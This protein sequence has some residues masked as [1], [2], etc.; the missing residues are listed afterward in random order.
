[1]PAPIQYPKV[2]ISDI[3]EETPDTKTFVLKP[4]DNQDLPY[5]AGQFIT[6]V[7]PE[8][9]QDERRSY[10]FSSS[11][12]ADKQV[13]IT[14][15]RIQNGAF[16]RK[17][18]DHTKIGDELAYSGISGFFKLPEP[19]EA[20]RQL[21]FF[22]AGSGIGPN[23]SLIKTVLS[24]YPSIQVILIYSNRNPENTI[25]F[26]ELI[27]LQKKHRD[28]FSI[29]FLMSN[30]KDILFSRLNNFLLISLLQKYKKGDWEDCYFFICG[31][32]DY[33]DTVSIT[34]L[35]EGVS[36]ATIRKEN[37]KSYIPEIKNIPTDKSKRKVTLHFQNNEYEFDVQYPQTI[38]KA[39]LENDIPLP[40]SCESGQCGTC[41]AICTKGKVWMSYNEVLMPRELRQ[42]IILTCTGY[43]I[44]GDIEIK[45]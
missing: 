42:N 22:A 30:N 14:V 16:S 17:L 41:S 19:I 33:M 8:E 4:K 27:E 18:I 9:G 45:I 36:P 3:I 26:K 43:P 34:L 38:L 32:V 2:I 6:L 20:Y 25:F 23:F 31:P 35:T 5:A 24:L 39:A 40:F 29:E 12:I 1:M 28:R 21:Y 37:F 7:F 44:D 10:S 15:K 13:F 11:P